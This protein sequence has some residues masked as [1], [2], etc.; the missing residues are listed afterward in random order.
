MNQTIYLGPNTTGICICGHS[1][2]DHHL[3]MVMNTQYFED[4]KE[5]YLPQECVFFG[6]NEDGGYDAD[7]KAHCFEY[8]D[9]GL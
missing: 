2:E 6:C 3:W 1:W 7:G 4:T 5:P 8:E 9:R